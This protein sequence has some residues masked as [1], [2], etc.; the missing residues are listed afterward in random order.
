MWVPKITSRERRGKDCLLRGRDDLQK[1]GGCLSIGH[2]RQRDQLLC[3]EQRPGLRPMCLRTSKGV[4]V[5]APGWGRQ[6]GVHPVA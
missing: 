4:C 2:S 3:K 5:A 6:G 1:M